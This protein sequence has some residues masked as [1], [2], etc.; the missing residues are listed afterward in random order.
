MSTSLATTAVGDVI[1]YYDQGEL[2]I[3]LVTA[4]I[5]GGMT[6]VPIGSSTFVATPAILTRYPRASRRFRVRSCLRYLR[7]VAFDFYN[8]F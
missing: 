2:R 5:E 8:Y 6:V 1:V 4:I 7:D 3:G